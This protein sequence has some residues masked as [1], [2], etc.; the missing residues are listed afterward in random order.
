LVVLDLTEVSHGNATGIGMADLT[1]R[2]MIDRVDRTA[3]Y[4]N[5]LTSGLVR[6]ARLPMAME[7]DRG[8]V[9]AALNTVADP[10]TARIA[11]IVNTS[12]LDTFWVTDTVLPELRSQDR[13][14]V[15]ERALEP[16]FDPNGRM[17][18]FDR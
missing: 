8:A 6:S 3:T 15:H 14:T 10:A 11:R 2:R 5:A 16:Q 17:L 9:D 7:D 1:T 12:K 13:L 18:P 4:A